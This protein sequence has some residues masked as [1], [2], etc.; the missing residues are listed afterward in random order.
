LYQLVFFS[1]S[2]IL[3]QSRIPQEKVE[4]DRY[5]RSKEHEDYLKRK[6]AEVPAADDL[7]PEEEAALKAHEEAVDEAFEILS[8]TGCKVADG[9]VEALAHWKLGK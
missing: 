4:E 5:I 3:T 9:T 2:S 7:S 6:A 1:T 8:K